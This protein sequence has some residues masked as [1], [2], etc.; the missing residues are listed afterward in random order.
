MGEVFTAHDY[1][2]GTILGTRDTVGTGAWNLVLQSGPTGA[3]DISF[4][5]V[6]CTGE[7]KETIEQ[8]LLRDSGTK[9]IHPSILPRQSH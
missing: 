4:P 9:I 1:Y 3:V 8:P 2:A 7:N 5:R 6:V